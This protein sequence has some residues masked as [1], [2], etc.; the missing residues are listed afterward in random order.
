LDSRIVVWIREFLLGRIQRVREGGYLSEEVRVML[1]V[2]QG[3]VLGPLRFL[4][5]V[6]DIARN[7]VSTIR[8]FADDSA[9]YRNIMNKKFVEK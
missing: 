2:Q 3:S 4:A 9:I 7:I 1:G 8:L 6:N 5:Y